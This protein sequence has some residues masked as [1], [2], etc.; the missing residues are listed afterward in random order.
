[1]VDFLR[2]FFPKKDDDADVDVDADT[3][4]L[5]TVV[6]EKPKG[7]PSEATT[8]PLTEEQLQEITKGS[9]RIEPP[10]LV[11]GVAH[12]VGRQRENNE[13]AIF[14][15]SANI[16]VD[17]NKLPMG[18]FIV[19]DGMGGHKNGEVASENAVRAMGNHVITKL[20]QPLFGTRPHPPDE[21]LQ[22]IMR[23]GVFEA[24]QAVLKNAPGGGSTLTAVLLMN[25]QMTIA[26]VGDSRAYAVYLDGRVQTLTRDHS[27]VER[28][29]EL[30]QI[31]AEE[32]SVHPQKSMLYR[33]LGQGEPTEP[34]IFTASL[35]QPGYL[36]ICSDGLWGVL[37]EDDIFN[38][39]TSAPNPQR[40]S[41]NLVD[42]ANSAGGPDNI[43]VILVRMSD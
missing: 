22:E 9:Q 4:P 40:A 8:A 13:D 32:A 6:E 38:I 14:Y 1:V 19:S 29:K 37:D 2:K 20:Y 11:M 7:V 28:L 33:A 34:D 15:F 18:L 26:H 41:Q 23:S 30:G 35:P 25:T 31:T 24:N 36:M 17:S 12:N 5:D 39:I 10:Q 42:A 43:A 27:L 16:S 21:S 3:L